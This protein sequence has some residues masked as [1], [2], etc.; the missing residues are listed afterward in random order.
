[1][2][3]ENLKNQKNKRSPTS[4]I[5]LIFF[6]YKY[7][8]NAYYNN[9]LIMNVKILWN[10]NNSKILF[11]RVTIWIEDLWLN[12]FITIEKVES[13]DKLRKELSITKEP[14][15]IIEEESIE[16]KDVIFEWIVPEIEEL[17]S[18]FISIIWWNSEW[19][20]CSSWGCPTWCSC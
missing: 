11:D 2:K 3:K 9:I 19:S 15:L 4:F 13:D 16:F 1:M 8:K 20:S 17:K 14:A 5:F 18:M 10:C 6:I 12:E 7:N